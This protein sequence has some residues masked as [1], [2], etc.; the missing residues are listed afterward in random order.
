MLVTGYLQRDQSVVNVIAT[1]ISN[2]SDW[3]D[4]LA[5]EGGA[6]LNIVPANATRHR[7]SAYSRLSGKS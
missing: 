4:N 2:L 5:G 7:L 3:L 1:R 6:P